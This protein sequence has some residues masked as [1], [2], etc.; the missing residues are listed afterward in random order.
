M[1]IKEKQLEAVLLEPKIIKDQRG[2]F[3]VPFSTQDLSD[4]GL[5][6]R[7]T[8][9][10]NHSYTELKGTVRGPNYQEVPYNQAKV[11]RC[12]RGRLYSVGIDIDPSSSNYGE[13]VGF[14]LSAENGLLMYL[15]NYYAHAFVTLEDNTELEYLTDNEFNY[16]SAKSI[17]WDALGIDWTCGGQVELKTE[18]MSDKNKNAPKLSKLR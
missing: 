13:H 4:L 3:S 11:I 1:N 17:K 5:E 10:L 14:E 2:W 7:T 9:Q 8:Y 18:I 15:P 12:I 6:W 16:E